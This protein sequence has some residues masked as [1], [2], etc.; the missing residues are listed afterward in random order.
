LIIPKTCEVYSLWFFEELAFQPNVQS[1]FNLS[2]HLLNMV[3]HYKGTPTKYPLQNAKHPW[4]KR[5]RNKVNSVA[6]FIER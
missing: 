4:L 6:F 5:R 2:P 3:P 1:N